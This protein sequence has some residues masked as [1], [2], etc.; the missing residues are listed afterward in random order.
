MKRKTAYGDNFFLSEGYWKLMTCESKVTN[1]NPTG[2]WKYDYV[3]VTEKW[4]KLMDTVFR[5][6]DLNTV[7]T[8]EFL[9]KTIQKGSTSRT[10][11]KHNSNYKKVE[12]PTGYLTTKER[13]LLQKARREAKGWKPTKGNKLLNKNES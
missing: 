4:R 5:S 7:I 6:H 9:I 1:Y 3:M 13:M 2:G 10:P 8:P 11:K 12:R